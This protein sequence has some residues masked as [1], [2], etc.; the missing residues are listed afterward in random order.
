MADR[1]TTTAT[2]TPAVQAAAGAAAHHRPA[3]PARREVV[4]AFR[5]QVASGTYQ[6]PVDAV[7]AELAAW[8]LCD[9]LADLE[10]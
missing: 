6:P 9:G 1:P 8:L 7:S 4:R 3:T 5:E 2:A 10:G